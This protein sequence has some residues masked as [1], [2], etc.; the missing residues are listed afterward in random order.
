[1]SEPNAGSWEAHP[2]EQEAVRYIYTTYAEKGLPIGKIT[3]ALNE[4]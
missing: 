4:K 3:A 1:V 2:L